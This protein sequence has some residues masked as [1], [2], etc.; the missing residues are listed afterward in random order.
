MVFTGVQEHTDGSEADFIINKV[1]NT[2][3]GHMLYRTVEWIQR[4]A[5]GNPAQRITLL[6]PFMIRCSPSN[7]T[8]L[9][10]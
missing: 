1:V 3:P 6:V 10:C 9:V 8:F 4:F 7:P 5:K 2:F